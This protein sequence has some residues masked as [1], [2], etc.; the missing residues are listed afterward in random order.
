MIKIEFKKASSNKSD[1]IT[2][3]VDATAEA[4]AKSLKEQLKDVKCEK[5]PNVTTTIV[6]ESTPNQSKNFKL[7]IKNSCCEEF[8]KS[9]NLN[10]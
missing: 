4:I 6:V 5:H 10:Y 8:K 2:G 1:F 3:I 7:F 9:I